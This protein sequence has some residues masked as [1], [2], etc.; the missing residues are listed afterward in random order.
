M[1]VGYFRYGSV[2]KYRGSTI[3]FIDNIFTCINDY[4][5]TGNIEHLIDVANWAGIAFVYDNHYNKHYTVTNKER[6]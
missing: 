4:Y 1:N 6:E 2:Q 5:A 3:D